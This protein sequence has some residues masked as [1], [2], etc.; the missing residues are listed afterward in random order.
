MVQPT[1]ADLIT[2]DFHFYFRC[3][4]MD[5]TEEFSQWAKNLWELKTLKFQSVKDNASADPFA[6]YM[7]P[8][9]PTPPPNPPPTFCLPIYPDGFSVSRNT[10]T[11]TC[12]VTLSTTRPN[13]FILVFIGWECN[14]YN[15]NPSLPVIS[16]PTFVSVSSPSGLSWSH[17]GGVNVT[18]GPHPPFPQLFV[19]SPYNE[20]IR[21]ED[22]K[23]CGIIYLYAVAP[24]ILT[25][26]TI[27]VTLSRSGS[28]PLV[29]AISMCAIAFNGLV[30]VP[31]HGT[32][33]D[34]TCFPIPGTP[35]N[36]EYTSDFAVYGDAGSGTA[37]YVPQTYATCSTIVYVGG[38]ITG[39]G[40]PDS[41]N[42][43]PGV[44]T[45]NLYFA[46]TLPNVPLNFI[47]VGPAI[48]SFT[49]TPGGSLP[50]QLIYIQITLIVGGIETMQSAQTSVT[51]PAGS[52][53]VVA[54]PNGAPASADHWNLY[55]SVLGPN[56]L[57]LQNAT[58]IS[59]G[60]AWT[61]PATGLTS[62]GAIAGAPY[63]IYTDSGEDGDMHL[64]VSYAQVSQLLTSFDQSHSVD[65]GF[66]NSTSLPNPIFAYGA[67]VAFGLWST[68]S[69]ALPAPA[70]LVLAPP[71]RRRSFGPDEVGRV[72]K[73]PFGGR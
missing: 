53:L 4:F 65:N 5:D 17:S 8:A 29:D 50:T 37:V 34:Y 58:P 69:G 7:P 1:N 60:T 71:R 42:L 38:G 2:A 30:N 39:G 73:P 21:A 63:D 26:E 15:Y 66:I 61:E 10:K 20:N 45:P 16:T 46:G 64:S 31:S 59:I 19:G 33:F 41:A 56:S 27:T 35:L 18:P 22:N 43:T 72:R 54:S 48:G 68:T 67:G 25:G 14:N 47:P 49:V 32:F 36:P 23:A 55:A 44:G 57:T 28:F 12:T 62:N 11:D 70:K 24:N 51:V 52:L 40:L 6:A 13:D 3:R 9:P